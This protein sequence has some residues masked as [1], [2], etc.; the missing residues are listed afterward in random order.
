MRSKGNAT[1]REATTSAHA[2]A[3]PGNPTPMMATTRL[4][5]PRP[6]SPLMAAPTSGS[7]GISQRWRLVVIVCRSKF[8]QI[9]LVHAESFARAEYRDDDGESDGGFRG[10]HDHHEENED[11]T[12]ELLPLISERDER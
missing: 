4:E 8:Q 6:S 5:N 12:I 9:H 3:A 10:R 11:F 1:K 7:S 2:K